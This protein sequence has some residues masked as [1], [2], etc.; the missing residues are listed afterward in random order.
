MRLVISF[1]RQCVDIIGTSGQS[2]EFILSNK[3]K[4]KMK[5]LLASIMIN[6]TY[7]INTHIQILS[8]RNFDFFN[9]FPHYTHN[10]EVQNKGNQ[11]INN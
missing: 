11:Y 8:L 3:L 5:K 1:R 4:Y 10:F 7:Y 2:L 9:V 6:E